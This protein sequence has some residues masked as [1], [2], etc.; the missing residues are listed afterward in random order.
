[1]SNVFMVLLKL[2]AF[3]LCMDF[4]ACLE[5]VESSKK[6]LLY[7]FFF[8]NN[9]YLLNICHF[10]IQGV[11]EIFG[12]KIC[13][14]YIFCLLPTLGYSELETEKM[15][16]CEH[17]HQK[18]CVNAVYFIEIL[19]KVKRKAKKKKKLLRF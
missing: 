11:H 16:A 8:F 7:V 14:R 5:I 18:Y 12:L 1:M 2:G 13:A 4:F 19:T 10:I 9:L 6:I 15:S 17:S 3:F